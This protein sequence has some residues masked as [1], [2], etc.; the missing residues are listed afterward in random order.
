MTRTLAATQT[1]DLTVNAA[2]DLVV[3]VDLAAVASDCRAA[4]QAQ[5]GEMVFA[6]DRGMPTLAVAWE[7]FDPAAFEAAARRVLGRVPEVT[8]V[9]SITAIRDGDQ[10]R[11]TAVIRTP[12]GE[13]RIDAGV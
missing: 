9:L 4:M 3:A 11:Y 10:L 12:Y 2:G 8:S 13:A 5:R 1:N 7:R 6:Q